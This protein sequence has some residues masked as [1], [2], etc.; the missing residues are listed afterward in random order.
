MVIEHDA[1]YAARVGTVTVRCQTL[2]LF[3]RYVHNVR[4]RVHLV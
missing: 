1:D 3:G 2:Q 4:R